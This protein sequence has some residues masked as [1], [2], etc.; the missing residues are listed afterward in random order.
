MFSVIL[1]TASRYLFPLLI[2]FSFFIFLRGHNEPGGGFVGGLI[3][4]SA[5]CLYSLG[6]GIS[7]ARELLG[8]DP[9]NLI[10]LGLFVAL[11][12]SIFSILFAKNFF[13]G[14]WIGYSFP[15]VGKV[16]TP[17]LFDLG[18]YL[19]VMGIVLKIIFSLSEEEQK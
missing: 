14:F 12:S 11:I 19:V 1:S 17:L 6:N 15:V 18:V 5:Y 2:L 7:K 10:S 16:G 3:A 9:A 4:A 8:I 13:T